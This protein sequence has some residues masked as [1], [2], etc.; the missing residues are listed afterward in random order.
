M[1]VESGWRPL[2]GNLAHHYLPPA[3][4]IYPWFLLPR[5]SHG[6]VVIDLIELSPTPGSQEQDEAR[7]CSF[8]LGEGN[9][10]EEHTYCNFRGSAHDSAAAFL[11]RLGETAHKNRKI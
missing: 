9:E 11:R 1:K 6:R 7:M 5:G 3:A 2:G 4:S 10:N 8:N